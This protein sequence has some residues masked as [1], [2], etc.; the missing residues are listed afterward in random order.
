MKQTKNLNY[1]IGFEAIQSQYLAVSPRKRSLKHSLITVRKGLLSIR[2]AKNEYV[3][4]AGEHFWLPI[5]CLSSLTVLPGAKYSKLDFSVRLSDPFPA[6]SGY[7]TLSAIA[8]NSLT[9]LESNTIT[10]QYRQILLQLMRFEVS[11]LSP[12]LELK[13]ISQQF[14]RWTPENRVKLCDDINTLLKL[15]EARKRL[16]S[17]ES[18]SN[19]SQQLFGISSEQLNQ[20]FE[21]NFGT[22]GPNS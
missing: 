19:V 2:L 15:R 5:D 1:S 6:Q 3:V 22:R 9:L 7:V 17:G 10:D 16:L 12:K 14:S 8:E 21:V 13:P 18:C 11:A 4:E 20:L